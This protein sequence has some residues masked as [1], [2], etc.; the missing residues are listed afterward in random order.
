MNRTLWGYILSS[1]ANSAQ[2]KSKLKIQ[3]LEVFSSIYFKIHKNRKIETAC[4]RGGVFE[5]MYFR[6]RQVKRK[7]NQ[8]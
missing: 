5:N 3:Y 7:Q 8:N 2:A 4:K 6:A 1:A